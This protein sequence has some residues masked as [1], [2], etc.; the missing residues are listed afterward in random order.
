MH[1]AA[2]AVPQEPLQQELKR[3]SLDLTGLKAHLGLDDKL[4]IEVPVVYHEEPLLNAAYV[5]HLEDQYGKRDAQE[6]VRSVY[7]YV[8]RLE[9]AQFLR[10]RM[11]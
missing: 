3:L 1:K 10:D 9:I 7:G 5:K 2:T 6:M 8:E 11:E 4:D